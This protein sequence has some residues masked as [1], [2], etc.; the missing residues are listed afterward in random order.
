MTWTYKLRA[1]PQVVGREAADLRRRRLHD[2]P[3]A[4]GGVAEL[5]SDGRR[6]SPPPRPT[7]RPSVHESTCRDPEAAD[8][9][10]LHPA[11]AH[12]GEVR[13][14]RDHQVRGARRCRLGPVHGSS[15]KKG[16]FCAIRRTRTTGAAS[17]RID[18]VVF[19]LFN[20]A[21]AMVAALQQRRDRRRRQCS[22]PRRSSGSEGARGS[23]RP[24]PAGRVRRDRD[25]RRRGPEEAAS[26]AARPAR[27]RSRSP[28]RS[29]SRRSSTGSA[30]PRHAAPTRSARRPNPAWIPQIPRRTSASTSTSRRRSRSSTTRATRT[31]TA[32]ASARC[33]AAASRSSFRY[34]VR[35]RVRD[36]PPPIAEFIS[37]WLQKIGIATT[38]ED[39]QTTA[40]SPRSSARA[41]TTCSSGAGRRTSIP[42]RCSRTSR[43]TR[44]PGP[45][46]PDEYYN[47]ANWCDPTTTRSTS[48]RTSSSTPPSACDIVHQ[49]L[50]RFYEAG[51][52]QRALHDPDL[53]AYRTD[54]F[55]GWL[56]QPADTGPV[57]FSN[58]SPTYAELGRWPR[59]AAVG[60]G[61]IGSAGSSG[62]GRR[63]VV[64]AA[65]RWCAAGECRRARVA[66]QRRRSRADAVQR[67]VVGKVLGALA[68][69]R[70]SSSS[71]SS[72]SAW[73]RATR[74]PTCS[75]GAT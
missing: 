72:S 37:G 75:A 8:D 48:S 65:R 61:G 12:L 70:S 45:E 28:T 69:L 64:I 30:R 63:V 43:A 6:T 11:E 24:G 23:H 9:G 29:T 2:Q 54:R 40:S 13:Q 74:S 7:R 4:Q 5:H 42:T 46:G 35:S 25:Q 21:D 20:N 55:T 38:A 22:R 73:S 67:F 41:T 36:R 49:M 33:P 18:E 27:A 51:G 44:S 62:S 71:T 57:L 47:D 32:T 31:P 15:V 16:Q 3:R 58:T 68:T 39:V 53:Q 17:P 59:A 50:T 10:R 52:L 66:A 26:G 14:G 56:R 34:A 60:G 1:E 19:R